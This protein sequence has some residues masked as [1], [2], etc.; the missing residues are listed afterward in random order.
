MVLHSFETIHPA[1]LISQ[2]IVVKLSNAKFV[3]ESAAHPARQV[4]SV[5]Q[6]LLNA[7]TAIDA[8]LQRLT[9]DAAEGMLNMAPKT[10]TDPLVYVSTSTITKCEE[11]CNA[12]AELEVILSRALSLLKKLPGEYELVDTLLHH[13]DGRFL[14]MKHPHERSAFLGAIKQS[15]LMN[16][17]VPEA[18]PT[19]QE[20]V[21]SNADPSDPCQL[22]A[23]LVPNMEEAQ[24]A[25]L[26]HG[27]LLLG[28]TRSSHTTS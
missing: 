5:A 16:P 2:V 18:S 4:R 20:Y 17:H 19:M 7:T 24:S 9:K 6:G 22:S 8:A 23:R 25:T 13:S 28:L 15:Q 27:S 10:M 11:A 26:F 3:L 14:F 21:L 1:A 12:I